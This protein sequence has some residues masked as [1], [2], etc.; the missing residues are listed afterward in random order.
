M[1][2]SR[3]TE[4]EGLVRC[5]ACIRSFERRGGTV[6]QLQPVALNIKLFLSEDFDPIVV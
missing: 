2:L 4:V 6:E 1:L 3:R 5:S